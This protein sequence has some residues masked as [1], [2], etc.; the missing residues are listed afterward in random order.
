[1]LSSLASNKQRGVGLSCSARYID[2]LGVEE[3]PGVLLG[4]ALQGM[5][6][7]LP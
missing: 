7:A 5:L 3:G 2:G 6:H 1:M 4:S